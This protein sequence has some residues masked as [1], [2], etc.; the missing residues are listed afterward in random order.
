MGIVK[1]TI[2]LGN[3]CRI[4]YVPVTA[5]NGLAIFYRSNCAGFFIHNAGLYDSVYVRITLRIIL[6]QS[7]YR[8]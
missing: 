6:I 8:N 7:S 2:L 4:A 5:Y 3:I 1:L